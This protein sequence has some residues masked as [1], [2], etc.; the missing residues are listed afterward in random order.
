M[1]VGWVKIED[2][3]YY[4]NAYKHGQPIGSMFKNYWLNYKGADYYLKEDGK[5]AAGETLTIEGKEY[6]FDEDGRAVV[7]E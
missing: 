6:S 2:V 5:M 7:T 4:F 1:K 3:W